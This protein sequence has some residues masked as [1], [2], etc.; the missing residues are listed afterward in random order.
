VYQYEI[1]SMYFTR[2]IINNLV[3]LIGD[4]QVGKTSL[5]N[6]VIGK[7]NMLSHHYPSTIGFEYA[8]TAMRLLDS[9][10]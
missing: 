10:K 9:N 8:T 1:E 2:I 4:C 7:D 5:L 6:E 3:I